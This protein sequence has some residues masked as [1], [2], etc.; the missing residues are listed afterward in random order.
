MGEYFLRRLNSEE[1]PLSDEHLMILVLVD[2]NMIL[3]ARNK[4]VRAF[5]LPMPSEEEIREAEELDRIA[6]RRIPPTQRRL[7]LSY[8]LKHSRTCVDKSINGDD[9]GIFKFNHGQ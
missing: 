3:E 9:N 2:I 8:D 1:H 7:Q 4:S 5:N 6:R